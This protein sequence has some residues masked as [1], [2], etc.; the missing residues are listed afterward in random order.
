MF[1][2]LQF[3]SPDI[4]GDLFINCYYCVI[5]IVLIADCFYISLSLSLSFFLKTCPS[6]F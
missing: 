2:C 5:N 1:S 3:H 6:Y 4:T